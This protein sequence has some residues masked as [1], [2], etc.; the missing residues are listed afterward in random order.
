V[1][2]IS[3]SFPDLPASQ[4]AQYEPYF[5]PY[6]AHFKPAGYRVM[7]AAILEALK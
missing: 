1:I 4:A 7:D 6:F 3:Q 2:D 5:Y